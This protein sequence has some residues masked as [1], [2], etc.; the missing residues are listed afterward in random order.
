MTDKV[1]P[2]QPARRTGLGGAIRSALAVLASVAA[3]LPW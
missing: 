1:Q 2:L 3:S